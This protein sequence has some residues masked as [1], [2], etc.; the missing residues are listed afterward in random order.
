MPEL[1]RGIWT[2]QKCLQ[3]VPPTSCE[4]L[5][6]NKLPMCSIH[7]VFAPPAIF[8]SV[9]TYT[10][11]CDFMIKSPNCPHPVTRSNRHCM[12]TVEIS[13]RSFHLR[14][15]TMEERGWTSDCPKF[16]YFLTHDVEY[17]LVNSQQGRHLMSGIPYG[18][19]TSS[20]RVIQRHNQER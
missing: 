15:C 2:T 7:S 8:I 1:T 14:Y 16:A 19:K 10:T 3:R 20:D 9:H 11:G 4:L 6:Q 5:L 12:C 18:L 17:L 13:S